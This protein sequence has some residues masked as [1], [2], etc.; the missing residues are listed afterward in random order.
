MISEHNLQGEVTLHNLAAFDSVNSNLHLI[1]SCLIL[2]Y[3]CI[4]LMAQTSMPRLKAKLT[5]FGLPLIPV[6]LIP[7]FLLA[8]Y[9]FIFYPTAKAD[10][11]GELFLGIAVLMWAVDLFLVSSKDKHINSIK[12]VLIMICILS[13]AVILSGILTY[14]YSYGL[15]GRL[16]LMASRDYPALEM[17]DQ[18]DSIYTYIY[19]NPHYL[20]PE[21]RINH[22]RMLQLTGKST[23]AEKILVDAA[24]HLEKKEP[25]KNS[26]S[27]QLRLLGIT[28]M[29]MGQDTLSDSY[30]N[31]S[32]D[33][34]Q[35]VLS[36]SSTPDDKAKALWSISKTMKARGDIKS[37]ITSMEQAIKHAQSPALQHKLEDQLEELSNYR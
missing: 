14:R 17:Y 15:G 24:S 16:N 30:F 25:F 13:L 3:L 37:A 22:A 34:E 9:F 36:Q 12:S 26:N 33:V 29:L 7:V 27:K 11:I 18:A 21:T 1:A 2:T 5:K 19:Q 23:E 6:R 20:A 32:I 35:N 10:E 31:K 8:P 28:Y 4:S